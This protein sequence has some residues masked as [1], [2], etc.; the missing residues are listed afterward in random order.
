MR[1]KWMSPRTEHIGQ[2]ELSAPMT[3]LPVTTALSSMNVDEAICG[4]KSSKFLIV[5]GRLL[6]QDWMTPILTQ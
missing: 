1:M 4:T 5:I 6:H 3:T 2:I